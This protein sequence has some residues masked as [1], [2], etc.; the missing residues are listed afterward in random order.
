MKSLSFIALSLLTAVNAASVTFK[1]IAPNATEKVQVDVGGHLT[2]LTAS[3]PDIPY[4][5]GVAELAVNQTYKYIVDGLHEKFDRTLSP[6][7]NGSSTLNEFFDR[8]VTYA[9][10]IPPLPLTLTQGA[11]TRGSTDDP[12]WDSNYIPTI[13]VTA[14]QKDMN[15]LILNVP[16]STYKAKITFIGP[17][18]VHSFENCLFGLHKPGRKHNDAKQSWVWSLPKGQFFANRNWFKIRHQEEDPTQIR[19]K[20]YADLLRHMG[21]YANEA[22]L[23]RF[24]INK[25]GMGTFNMLDDVIMYS[26]ISAMFYNGKPPSQMGGLY[27]GATGADFNP[28]T[29]YDS[30]IPNVES[31]V[32]QYA[33]APF[34]EAFAAVDYKNDEQVKA[35][36]QWFD[37]DQYL[38]F[39]IMEYLTGSWDAYWMA[40]TNDGAYIDSAAKPTM[41]YYLPQDFDATFGVNLAYPKSFINITVNEWPAKFN[42]A[43]LINNFVSNPTLNA[44]F[45]GYL[46]TTVEELFNMKVLEPYIT[47]RHKFMWPDL[48]WDRSIKQRSPGNVYGWTAKQTKENLYKGVTAP[49]KESGGAQWGLLEWIKAKEEV[50]RRELNITE[51]D[52]KDPSSTSSAPV[53]TATSTD[54]ASTST[55]SASVTTIILSSVNTATATDAT[56]TATATDAAHKEGDKTVSAAAKATS[57]SVAAKEQY[58]TSGASKAIPQV[59]SVMAIVGVI[60]TALF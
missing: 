57:T 18:S 5:T 59:L 14:N 30:F 47:A 11:W 56:A 35:I 28:K 22:N 44:T 49:G 58:A 31:P 38:R 45:R 21:T 7:S 24:F 55:A 1:L 43:F 15:N 6:K 52:I 26:Y 12:I 17:D 13:F 9:T 50:A 32:D 10:D 19:E 37:V 3:D 2:T 51:S 53:S 33:L 40:Q 25:E 4:F 34:A 60:A 23:V 36:N 46:K 54:S 29:G 41:L 39:M 42:K 20:L 27:D 16:K 8:P 48:V